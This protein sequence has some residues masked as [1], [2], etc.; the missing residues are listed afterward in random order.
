MFCGLSEFDCKMC[1][2]SESRN[3][4]DTPSPVSNQP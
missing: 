1:K 4:A 2:A 3:K